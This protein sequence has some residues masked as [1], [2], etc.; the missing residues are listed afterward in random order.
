[1]SDREHRDPE[2]D[3]AER[4]APEDPASSHGSDLDAR[5][6]VDPEAADDAQEQPG[7]GDSPSVEEPRH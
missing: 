7:P 5:T 1:M 4:P 3:A 2:G 6:L